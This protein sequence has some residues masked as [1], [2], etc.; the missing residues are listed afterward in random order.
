VLKICLYILIFANLWTASASAHQRHIA[1]HHVNGIHHTKTEQAKSLPETGLATWYAGGKYKNK[2]GFHHFTS[3]GDR[4][5]PNQMT[6]AHR[7]LPFNTLIK[8]VDISTGRSIIVRVNDRI[9]AH[10]PRIIDLTKGAAT[11]LGIEHKGIA[12]VRLEPVEVAEAP[13]VKHR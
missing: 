3:S 9:R 5:D 11:A 1:H 6:C 10:P 2:N 8:V 7:F 4:L 12:H 13:A